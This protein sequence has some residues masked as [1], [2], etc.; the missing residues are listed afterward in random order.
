MT[1]PVPPIETET[2][3][4]RRYRMDVDTGTSTVTW[5]WLPGI[6]EL[7][8][9]VDPTQQASTTYDDDGWADQ[10][11]T[12]LSWSVELKMLHRCHPTTKAFNLAQ[13]TLRKAAEQFGSGARVHV[14]WYDR[15]GRDEA[16]EG[17]ALVKWERDGTAT[18]DLDSVKVTLAGKGKRVPI[19][20]PLAEE[21]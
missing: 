6:Q 19:A 16:Y 9:K 8:P 5:A 7:D 14:R 15:E 13:E 3:L 12:E 2:A 18:D 1:S 21:G 10:T 4:A 20:N 11:V 17:Y